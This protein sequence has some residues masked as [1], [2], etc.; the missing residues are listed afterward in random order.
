MC[1][2]GCFDRDLKSR[3]RREEHCFSSVQLFQAEITA[4]CTSKRLKIFSVLWLVL[5]RE[6][7]TGWCVGQPRGMGSP[8]SGCQDAAL[9]LCLPTAMPAA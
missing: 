3:S 7:I 9:A 2:K 6:F 1:L 4:L 5:K 8:L